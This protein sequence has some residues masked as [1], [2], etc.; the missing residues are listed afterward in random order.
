MKFFTKSLLIAA[1]AAMALLFN[2]CKNNEL[3]D[4]VE[5]DIYPVTLDF[6]IVDSEGNNLLDPAREDNALSDNIY[7][8]FEGVE[9]PVIDFTENPEAI[10]HSR[11]FMP[12]FYGL[13]AYPEA[14][15]PYDARAKRYLSFGEFNG[16]RNQ[17]ITIEFVWPEQNQR[18]TARIVRKYKMNGNEPDITDKR[19]LDG[20]QTDA[21]SFTIVRH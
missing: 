6:N 3:D 14:Y 7:V 17:D 12:S 11:F 21:Y 8:L 16:A 9:Y 13:V 2:S 15:E 10:D 19:Y 18:H 4:I 20:E 5:W 1:V